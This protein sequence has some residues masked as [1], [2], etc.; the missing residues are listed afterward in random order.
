MSLL[1]AAAHPERIVGLILIGGSARGLRAP[2]YPWGSTREEV[3]EHDWRTPGFGDMVAADMA[4]SR[5]HDPRLNRWYGRLITFG[6]SPSSAI[7]LEKMN[8]EID[9]RA[10][11]PAIHVPTLVLAEDSGTDIEQGKY[12]AENVSCAKFVELPGRDH[13]SWQSQERPRLWLPQ[14]GSL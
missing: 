9:V 4:P 11:L 3:I 5:A 2:D 7:A 12:I 14:L 6:G 10:A 1:F 8:M 13:Y